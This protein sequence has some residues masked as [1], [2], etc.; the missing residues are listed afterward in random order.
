M[1]SIRKLEL[2]STKISLNRCSSLGLGI[3][4][5]QFFW[6]LYNV[7][8]LQEKN[9]LLDIEAAELQLQ[10]ALDCR[11]GEHDRESNSNEPCTL[12]LTTALS[13]QQEF[14][15]CLVIGV[16]L[17]TQLFLNLLDVY[18]Y[19][20]LRSATQKENIYKCW[21]GLY[22][23]ISLL[24]YNMI[25]ILIVANNGVFDGSSCLLAARATVRAISIEMICLF[26]REIE[27]K[28][29]ADA[30]LYIILIV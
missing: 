22:L 20:I 21:L 24:T 5:L 9:A 2:S 29:E 14:R 11:T 7:L 10:K 18:V 26:L 19:M 16:I 6:G 3:T 1:Y 15:R 28:Q 25:E 17:Y 13:P 27:D 4:T 30:F 8:Q 12:K 23:Q